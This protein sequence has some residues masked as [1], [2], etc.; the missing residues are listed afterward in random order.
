MMKKISSLA[1]MCF[2]LLTAG[3]AQ[4]NVSQDMVLVPAGSFTFGTNAATMKE[5]TKIYGPDFVRDHFVKEKKVTLP[6][7]YIDK[8]EVTNRQFNAFLKATGRPLLKVAN[9]KL[10]HPVNNIG[11]K[12][13]R[14]YAAWAGKRLPTEEEWEKAAKGPDNNIYPWGA[15]DFGNNYNGS[16]QGNYNTVRVGMY[17]AGKSGYG[18]LDASGNV[19]EMTTGR[20]SDSYCMR[21]GSFL[22]KG[23]LVMTTFRWG[24]G[25]TVNGAGWLGFRC[26]K[27]L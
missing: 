7:F 3:Y 12:S 14:E 9:D 5:L 11:W 25:D 21:G 6:A 19:Y 18:M 13:A 10:D 2:T 27:D 8:C 26:V 24:P 15:K 16:A 20:W 23:A 4:K 22:N 17:P 1:M